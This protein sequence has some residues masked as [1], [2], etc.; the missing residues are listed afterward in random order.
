M[1]DET[2]LITTVTGG[3]GVLITYIMLAI[4]KCLKPLSKKFSAVEWRI[5]SISVLLTVASFLGIILYYSFKERLED[6]KRDLFLAS[7]TV[8]LI[9]A[10]SWSAMINWIVK[11]KKNINIQLIFL[12]LTALGCLGI[13]VS[14]VYS[15]DDWLLITAASILLFHHLVF[16]SVIWTYI[17][18]RNKD[19]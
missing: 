13:L 2:V 11:N 19:H 10:M 14:I 6:W 7:L 15:T 18:N 3:S 8:F 5:W 1:K 9:S 12:I 4:N 17:H 16:D